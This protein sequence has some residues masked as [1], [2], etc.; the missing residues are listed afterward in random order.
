MLMI[1]QRKYNVPVTVALLR[2]GLITVAQQDQQLARL[3]WKDPRPALT[4]FTANLIREC[5]LSDPPVATQAQ[6]PES[7][8]TLLRASEFG[9]LS[10]TASQLLEDFGIL[11]R[12]RA[13]Q[14]GI[15]QAIAESVAKNESENLNE[16]LYQWFHQWVHVIQ[17]S[18]SPEK[19]FIP[20][21]SR[22]QKEGILKQEDISFL[23]FRVC[24]EAS[25]EIYKTSRGTETDVAFRGIDA[26]SKL[27][28]LIIRYHGDVS[29]SNN[30]QLKA[31]YLTKILSIV[32]VVLAHA[33]EEQEMAF[34]QKPFFRFF[35]S[36]L[37]DLN[38]IQPHVGSAY[39]PLML[40]LRYVTEL[41]KKLAT[42]FIFYQ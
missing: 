22:L 9:K 38:C 17:Q 8:A 34:E 32:V 24:T 18:T 39:F 23:F 15:S 19:A 35:S 40:A 30:D 26:L 14:A 12:Q 5:I 36:L 4:D 7:I 10:D 33:H 31:H 25:V 21:V 2:S 27:I 6:F 11:R 41:P 28:S 29:A 13:P 16:R 42:D 1:F 3:I 37:N 20:F